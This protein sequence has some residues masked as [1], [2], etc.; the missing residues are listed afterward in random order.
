M[1]F[2]FSNYSNTYTANGDVGDISKTNTACF[3]DVFR[4]LD[5][6][7][8]KYFDIVYTI[9]INKDKHYVNELNRNN[10]CFLTKKELYN[11]IKILKKLFD[12]NFNV[13]EEEDS[14]I[15][16]AHLFNSSIVHKYFLTWVRYSYEYPYNVM[17]LDALNL[18]KQPEFRFISKI[19]IFNLFSLAGFEYRS[20]HCF[21]TMGSAY[22]KYF[23]NKDLSKRLKNSCPR[24]QTLFL[25]DSGHFPNITDKI[26][27]VD[28]TDRNELE[29][30]FKDR[31]LVYKNLYK[32]Y[33]ENLCCR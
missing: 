21:V 20:C 18:R 1:A 26:T 10:Y 25:A 12:F 29:L 2:Q 30:T 14:Y 3:S 11:H 17:C 24:V 16:S 5:N 9:K 28:S 33:H 31:L 27:E 32:I 15:V 4:V 7:R 6:K 22:I 23:T 13:K 8:K 19:N